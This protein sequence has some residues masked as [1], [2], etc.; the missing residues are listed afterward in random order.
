[1]AQLY[2]NNAASTLASSIT[3]SATSI[4]LATGDGAKFPSP[5]GG[6]YFLATL[7]QRTGVTESNWEIVKCTARSGDVLTIVRAQESTT[8]L[9]YNSGDYVELRLTAGTM[10]SVSSGGSTTSNAAGYIA[11]SNF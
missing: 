11:F 5:T 3:N 9:A 1:M 10:T 4:T 2:A 6:D 8:A 7:F